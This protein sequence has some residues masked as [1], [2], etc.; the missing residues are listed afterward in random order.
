MWRITQLA[1]V[2]GDVSADTMT[3]HDGLTAALLR[4]SA[5]V[6]NYWNPFDAALQISNAKTFF[7]DP[8][9]GRV[10]LKGELDDQRVDVNCGMRWQAVAKPDE[11]RDPARSHGWYFE[12]DAFYRDLAATL[13]GRVDRNAIPTREPLSPNRLRLKP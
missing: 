8:R 13:D 12:D 6:T 4:H 7:S 9:V 11:L 1:L 5:R 2:A 3:P 10:G